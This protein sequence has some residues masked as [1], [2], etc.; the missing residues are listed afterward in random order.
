MNKI[1]FA[2][3]FEDLNSRLCSVK[4]TQGLSLRPR[5]CSV[6]PNFYSP[7]LVFAFYI[8]FSSSPCFLKIW[9]IYLHIFF[10]VPPSTIHGWVLS[11]FKFVHQYQHGASPKNSFNDKLLDR[12]SDDTSFFILA[13]KIIIFEWRR[14]TKFGM[15]L[16]L[17]KPIWKMAY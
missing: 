11:L 15:Q 6:L 9:K 5:F 1:V 8:I 3:K 14:A 13:R 16:D 12:K 7:I 10:L 4:V 2:F 17:G